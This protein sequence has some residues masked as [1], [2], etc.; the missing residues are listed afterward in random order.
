M[1]VLVFTSAVL[2]DNEYDKKIE[3]STFCLEFTNP[4][5]SGT[6]LVR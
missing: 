6:Y 3:A 2:G 5:A 1:L 4:P